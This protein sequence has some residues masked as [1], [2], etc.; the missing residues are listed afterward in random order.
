[1]IEELTSASV[2][3]VQLGEV[4]AGNYE[5]VEVLGIGGMGVVYKALQR[6]LGR[7]VAI[8]LPRPELVAD[9][10]VRRRLRCE[11]IAGARIDHRN[12]V[13]VLDFGSHRGIPFVVMEYVVGPR[14]AQLLAEHGPLPVARAFRIAREIVAG[15]QGAHENG[16]VHADVKCDNV[17]VES[18]RDG[19]LMP[20]LID[21]G[22]ARFVDDGALRE[23]EDTMISGT[24]DYLAPEV[25]RGAAPGFSADVYALGVMLY[26][27]V[28]GT[29]P[30]GGGTSAAVMSRA[31]Q[32]EPI[33]LILRCPDRA[34]PIGF[35]AVVMRALD[36]DPTSRYADASALGLALD[37]IG[38][39]V[40][41]DPATRKHVKTNPPIF[42]TEATTVTMS[43]E[44]IAP[45]RIAMGSSELDP[46]TVKNCTLG[47]APV[48]IAALTEA[49]VNEI[50]VHCLEVARSHIDEHRLAAAIDVVE[51][52]VAALARCDGPTWRLWLTLA[53]LYDGIANRKQARLAASEARACAVR[54]GSA[55]GVERADE[56]LTRLARRRSA[57]RPPTPW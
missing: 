15:L 25:I 12:I 10:A 44:V 32:D 50:V 38:L 46:A 22:I 53:A 23:L 2:M 18:L 20:R 30:F 24:P 41:R 31:I 54:A 49:D 56:L 55:A 34:V 11:A 35:D 13:R 40:K 47:P 29:T 28:S 57:S 45:R 6:S 37:R 16:V 42:S 51:G 8:K 5:I 48:P 43:A 39:D 4:V 7:F 14:L 1:M 36:K 17:L 26:E 52:G 9:L 33:P 3:S 21:F 19:S 27:L